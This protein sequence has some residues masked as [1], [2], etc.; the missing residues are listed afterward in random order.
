MTAQKKRKK[1]EIHSRSEK[2]F[3]L[4]KLRGCN[5]A[6][7]HDADAANAKGKKSRRV[8]A[9]PLTRHTIVTQSSHYRYTIVL[10][11]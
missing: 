8:R 10:R 6:P 11:S 9:H 5:Y 3:P 7:T 1:K 2:G 4:S